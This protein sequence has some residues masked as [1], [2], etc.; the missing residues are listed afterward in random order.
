MGFP[1]TS[2]ERLQWEVL[3]TGIAAIAGGLLAYLGATKPHERTTKQILIAYRLKVIEAT[4]VVYFYKDPDA[5][6]LEYLEA[7]VKESDTENYE[8]MRAEMIQDAAA[9]LLNELEMPPP[10][11]INNELN[12]LVLHL[13][14]CAKAMKYE[15]IA[16]GM[17]IPKLF[18]AIES[19]R[20][21]LD[22]K[23]K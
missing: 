7:M 20:S 19:L 13:R 2:S 23:C 21:H 4:N 22:D 12:K 16:H 1:F 15:I 14:V 9:K 17:G 3:A 11:I 18:I 8:T 10:E 6:S 5:H